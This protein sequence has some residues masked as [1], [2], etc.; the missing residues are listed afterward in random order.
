MRGRGW[1]PLWVVVI[2]L[3]LPTGA[4]TQDNGRGRKWWKDAA[5][6][7]QLGLSDEQSSKI[8]AIYQSTVPQL[9]EQYEASKAEDAQ[10]RKL[11]DANGAEDA[12]A[13]QIDRMETAHCAVSRTRLLMLY[14]MRL[15]LTPDQRV[16]F[17]KVHDDWEKTRH[18]SAGGREHQDQGQ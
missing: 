3:L 10:L 14:K 8:D 13:Q 5:F 18:K 2:A 6:R 11:V 7:Q 12:V 4:S 17:R 9:R 1:L 15:V 16:K